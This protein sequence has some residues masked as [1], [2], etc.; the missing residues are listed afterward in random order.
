MTSKKEKITVVVVLLIALVIGLSYA[1]W[2]ANY[3]QKEDN[4]VN[5]SC[6][7]I[8][9]IN[10]KNDINLEKAYPIT[11][12]EASSLTPYE[13]EI[14][15]NCD[16][17]AMYD[18]NVEIL[19]TSTL[20]SK[21][22][23][24]KL[25]DTVSLLSDKEEITP[26]LKDASKGYKIITGVVKAKSTNK[27]SLNIWMD[28]DTPPTSDTMNKIFEIKVSV[29]STYK[30]V[31]A[32][33]Y[34]TAL[35]TSDSTNLA[36]DDY[37]NTRYIGANPNNYVSIDGELWRIIG[38]MKDIDDGT[39]IKEDRIKLIR[40]ESIGNYSWD[41][42]ASDVNDGRGVNEWS[43]ADLMKLLN[44]GYENESV[45]GSLYWNNQSGTCYNGQNNATTSC[46]F[47]NKGIKESLKKLINA[48]LWNTGSNGTNSWT[49]ANTGL[50]KN[51]YIYERSDSTGKICS[52]GDY[53]N[54][55]IKRTTL[56]SG[57]VGLM[58]PSDYGYSV[59]QKKCLIYN[60]SDLGDTKLKYCLENAWLYVKKYEWTI[61]PRAVTNITYDVFVVRDS[62]DMSGGMS[63][64]SAGI[65]PVVYLKSSVKIV[66]G[67]GTSD[68]AFV[69]SE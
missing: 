17:D 50:A 65:M 11:D 59:N 53:C 33:D 6:F 12:E 39:G 44:P 61:M 23:K 38:V 41:T 66:S 2:K 48:A 45:G 13:F 34:V 29:T 26:V 20:D 16:K 47:T 35:G 10:E 24:V 63:G 56:W 3:E 36:I 62:G 25:N 52:S 8:K 55:N 43:Q 42:S 28:Y 68:N 18:V 1:Y 32:V 37:G 57:L 60:I 30:K 58:Y 7:N 14:Q 40:N 54:D 67:D 46:D 4:V 27:Y 64:S 9:Y 22:V 69:L 49:T 15:N 31:T 21:Y 51:F 19:N 5:S